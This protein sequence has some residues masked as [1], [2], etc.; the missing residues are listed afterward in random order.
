MAFEFRRPVWPFSG[1]KMYFRLS[2]AFPA[3][4]ERRY[5]ITIYIDSNN[6]EVPA[7]LLLDRNWIKKILSDL[8]TGVVHAIIEYV[9]RPSRM[10]NGPSDRVELMTAFGM[11]TNAQPPGR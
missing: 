5:R 4:D 2:L 9:R 6:S 7:S 8:G 11:I 10:R 1:Q 3:G